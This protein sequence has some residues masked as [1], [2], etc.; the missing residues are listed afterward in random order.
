MNSAFETHPTIDCMFLNAGTQSLSNFADPS[1][2]DLA[3]FHRE[4]TINFSAQV[5][6][7]HAALPHLLK[8]SSRTGLIFT[9]TQVSLVPIFS[10]PSYSTSKAALE[11]F[12]FCLR[13]QL[14][15][16]N[17]SV[18]QISPGPVQTELHEA[19]SGKEASQK[20]GMPLADFVNES[21]AGLVE[22]KA[23]IYSGC[24]GGSTKEQFLELVKLRD[25]AE[26]RLTTL[27]RS[28][29]NK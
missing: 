23:D 11:S 4:I 16:T 27:L 29:M 17:V 26:A 5:A 20:F 28:A 8:Q 3:S 19:H 21:W 1:F 15:D 6:L 13:A 12:I 10:M 14:R 24:V 18:Q 9:G 22:G 25:E 2:V 7:V